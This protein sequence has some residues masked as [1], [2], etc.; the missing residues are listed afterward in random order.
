MSLRRFEQSRERWA[1]LKNCR[2][3]ELLSFTYFKSCFGMLDFRAFNS[4]G[5][6]P[7]L[8][9][10]DSSLEFDDHGSILFEARRFEAHNSDIG[11]G[12]RLPLLENLTLRIQSISI[13][14][15]IRTT[16]FIPAQIGDRILRNVGNR[17]ACHDREREC[18]VNERP[19]EFRF[20][21]IGMIEVDRIGVHGQQ[22]KPNIVGGK[23]SAAQSVA[24]NISN[25]EVLKNSSC[26]T[27]FDCHRRLPLS[28]TRERQSPDWRRENRQ[29]GDWRSREKSDYF[30]TPP[31][32]NCFSFKTQFS[33]NSIGL[34]PQCWNFIHNGLYIFHD[35]GGKQRRQGAHG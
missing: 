3:W 27:L 2:A 19:A 29:S 22:G 34:L 25:L 9:N 5:N 35:D 13:K 11:S 23:N 1:A 10:H 28:V 24:K 21:R 6:M 33:Q 26:P 15:R 31:A 4:L 14:E 32:G 30:F 20:R 17:L 12:L 8:I 18:R 7:S 16:H